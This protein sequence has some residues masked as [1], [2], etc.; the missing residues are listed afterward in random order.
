MTPVK[1]WK[2]WMAVSCS[3]GDCV[4]PEAREQVLKFRDRFKPDT[5]LHLGDFI[6]MAAA[7]SGAMSDPNAKDRAAS[8]AEDLAAGVDFLQELRPNHI[9]YGN[10]EARLFGLA[11]GPNALAS[12]AATLVIQEIERTAKAL[13]AR[14]YPYN[15]RSYVEIGGTKFLHG[16]MFNVQA[17]RDHAET[18]GRC[19]IGHLH[20]V[21]QERAR[22]LDGVSGYC[23]GMLA[24]F[25]M[26]YAMTRR[27]TLAWSQGFAYGHYTD[28]H[29]TINLCERT[30]ENPWVLPL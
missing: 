30:K 8:V 3:H 28:H 25:D 4:D 20:R 19:V 11:G 22:T 5:I 23:V 15:I 18:Y 17:I 2:K 14:L 27:A 16:Y 12:H 7:R 29:M 24:R 1:K 13:K 9:L 21:G 10:H 26:E 6:D